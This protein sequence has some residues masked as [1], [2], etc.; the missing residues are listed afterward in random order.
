MEN[1][2]SET[3]L[4]SQNKTLYLIIVEIVPIHA[5]LRPWHCFFYSNITELYLPVTPVDNLKKTAI[6]DL[7][8][9]N[10]EGK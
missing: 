1:E 7:L 5:K 6:I 3:N 2:T 8:N 4:P 10:T 9:L